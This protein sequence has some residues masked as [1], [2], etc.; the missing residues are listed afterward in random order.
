MRYMDEYYTHEGIRLDPSKIKKNAGLRPLAKLMLVSF[1]ENFSQKENQSK[2]TI[3]REPQELFNLLTNPETSVNSVQLIND[4][5]VLVNWQYIEEVG[6]TLKNANV[7]IA[8]YTTAQA[9]L[10][11]YEHLQTTRASNLLGHR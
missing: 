5:M 4:E 2:A 11:L 10:N 6:E 3:I 9:R 8:T 7:V 1:W